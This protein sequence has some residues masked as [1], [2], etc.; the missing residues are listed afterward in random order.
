VD[1]GAGYLYPTAF[2]V[3]MAIMLNYIW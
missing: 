3:A 2:Y 1:S